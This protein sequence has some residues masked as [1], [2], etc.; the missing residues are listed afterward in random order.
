LIH[1]K[2]VDKLADHAKQLDAYLEDRT[3]DHEVKVFIR[4]ALEWYCDK[5]KHQLLW[6]F[7][8]KAVH[9]SDTLFCDSLRSFVANCLLDDSAFKIE[10]R[11]TIYDGQHRLIWLP[12]GEYK[13]EVTT[14]EDPKSTPVLLRDNDGTQ[15]ATLLLE[16]LFIADQREEERKQFF[17]EFLNEK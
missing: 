16:A 10:W 5:D 14:K 6:E 11:R 7:M 17:D 3:L 9:M 2:A 15:N 8:H 12:N 13:T 1:S 4:R